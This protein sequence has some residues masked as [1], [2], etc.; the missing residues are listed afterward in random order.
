MLKSLPQPKCFCLIE[1]QLCQGQCERYLCVCLESDTSDDSSIRSN[2]AHE[3]VSNAPSSVD[4][5]SDFRW[6]AILGRN[7]DVQN[8][9]WFLQTSLELL[10]QS[11]HHLGGHGL[12]QS[13]R[14]S[15]WRF[16]A[17]FAQRF[18]HFPLFALF[19]LPQL[20]K[21]TRNAKIVTEVGFTDVCL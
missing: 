14:I 5:S 7:C 16:C 11:G 18:S 1:V 13:Q 9:S 2:S 3:S 20:R 8:L 12:R 10:S 21:C 17:R 6:Q 15:A 19:G 4:C